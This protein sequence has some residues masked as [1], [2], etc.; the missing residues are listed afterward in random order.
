ML[1]GV[2]FFSSHHTSCMCF[3]F[4]PPKATCLGDK[5]S[6][7]GDFVGTHQ[8]CKPTVRTGKGRPG[9]LVILGWAASFV[10]HRLDGARSVATSGKA[11]RWVLSRPSCVKGYFLVLFLPFHIPVALSIPFDSFPSP[12]IPNLPRIF[13]KM[14]SSHSCGPPTP[15]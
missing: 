12:I 13:R 4:S 14:S 1:C 7:G 10:Q 3:F 5:S 8:Y 11:V 15:S 9:H 6:W 2:C